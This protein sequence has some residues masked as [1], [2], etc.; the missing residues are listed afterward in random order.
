[1]LVVRLEKDLAVR[2]QL[3]TNLVPKC[4]N[5]RSCDD[6]ATLDLELESPG[7]FLDVVGL[8]EL[9]GGGEGQEAQDEFESGLY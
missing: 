5:G 3:K 8:I 9:V 1:M 4:D 7:P 2:K 6:L